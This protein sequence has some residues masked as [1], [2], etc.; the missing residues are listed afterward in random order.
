IKNEAIIYEDD[1]GT[2]MD[3]VEIPAELKDKASEYRTALIEAIA[4][5]DED[6]MEKY[7]DGGEL[8]QEEIVATLRK[9]VIANEIVP[10]LCGS[11]YK[12][13]GV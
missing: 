13:K 11:S 12:N 2:V 7:L 9:G 10:V 3:E 6:I 4:E 1:L 5:L 8:T